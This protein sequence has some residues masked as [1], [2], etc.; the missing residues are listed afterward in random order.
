MLLI[1]TVFPKFIIKILYFNTLKT[2]LY[3]IPILLIFD[4]Q[5]NW[6]AHSDSKLLF[7]N[8]IVQNCRHLKI[9]KIDL[10]WGTYTGTLLASSSFM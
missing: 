5:K 7:C 2:L 9:Y 3:F 4:S 8:L 1:N 10:G 6:R